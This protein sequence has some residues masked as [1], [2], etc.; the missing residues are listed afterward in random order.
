L[1]FAECLTRAGKPDAART[2]YEQFLTFFPGSPLRP[3][4]LFQMASTHFEAQNYAQAAV[5][6]TQMLEDSTT[7]EVK[8]AA[9]FNLAQ[10]QRQLGATAEAR[11]TLDRYTREHPKDERAAQVAYVLGDLDEAAGDLAAAESRYNAAL[12]ARPGATLATEIHYR[13]GRCSE[14][15]NDADAALRHYQQAAASRDADDAYR[16]S[17]L[18]RCASLYEARGERTRAVAA[19]RDIAR[20]TSDQELAAAAAARAKEL[21]A[22]SDVEDAAP[23]VPKPKKPARKRAK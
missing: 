23:P 21:H 16:L 2:A 12:A 10:C 22:G 20:H 6:F 19:Y 11:S 8:A 18:A 4:V 15:R 17:A 13:L 3:T 1:L 9:L 7:A 5:H 14:V